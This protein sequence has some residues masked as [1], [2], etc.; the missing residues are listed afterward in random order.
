MY[1]KCIL[2]KDT[3]PYIRYM[4]ISYDGRSFRYNVSCC[5]SMYLDVYERDTSKYMQ[6]TCTIHAGYMGYVSYRKKHQNV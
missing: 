4:Y 6:D 3:Y 5:I 1:P 2:K